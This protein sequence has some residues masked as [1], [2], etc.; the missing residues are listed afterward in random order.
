MNRDPRLPWGF[1]K[2]FLFMR[3][4][5]LGYARFPW[6]KLFPPFPFAGEFLGTPASP[7]IKLLTFL[8]R[9]FLGTRV[10]LA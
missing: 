5:I 8:K 1:F 4:R 9:E 6:Q 2:R 7:G 3:T 10:P